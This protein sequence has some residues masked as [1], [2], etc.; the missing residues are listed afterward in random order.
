MLTK[1]FWLDAVERAGKTFAQVLLALF[2]TNTVFD[3]THVS[4]LHTLGVAFSATVV[5][6]LTSIGST[7]LGPDNSASL[8]GEPPVVTPA[9]NP[10]TTNSDVGGGV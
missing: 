5:S 8:V 6:F 2:S 4:F 7:K 10:A 9:Y 3:I 1:S